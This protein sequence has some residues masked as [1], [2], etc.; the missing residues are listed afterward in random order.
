MFS[1]QFLEKISKDKYARWAVDLTE[2]HLETLLW[3]VGEY[4]VRS[5]KPLELL[6]AHMP[7]DYSHA[8]A[9]LALE[10]LAEFVNGRP[11]SLERYCDRVGRMGQTSAS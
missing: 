3:A 9:V 2:D 4:G 5:D 11:I 6:H 8:R 10:V 1:K 7:R